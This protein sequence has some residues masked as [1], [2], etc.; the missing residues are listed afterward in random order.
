MSFTNEQYKDKISSLYLEQGQATALEWA[1]K[2]KRTKWEYCD[3][4]E[5]ETA[6]LQE[7]HTCLIC[8][9]TT[10]ALKEEED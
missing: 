4:C 6:V 8:G 10:K 7:E 9:S 2:Q 3:M 1:G 5:C